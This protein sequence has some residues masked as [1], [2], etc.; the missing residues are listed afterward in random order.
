MGISFI[1][2]GLAAGAAL[3]A[4]P[5]ILHLLMRQTPKVVVFPALR[6]IRERSKQARKNMKI[7]NWLLL[8]ARMLLFV[9]MAL[10]L[11][12]PTYT[13]N[14]TMGDRE[15]PTALAL[16]F[17]TSLSMQ[18]TERNKDRLAEA[19]E[20]ALDLLSKTN[21][22][23]QVFVINSADPGVPV[24]LSP[25]A[26]KKQ[27]EALTLRPVNRK[28]NA[29]MGQAYSA[30]L[31][32]DRPRK[33]VYVLTDLARSAWDTGRPADGLDKLEKS[34][35]AVPTFVLRLSP[36]EPTNVG[37]VDAE[38]GTVAGITTTGESLTVKGV[39][40]STGPAA[41]RVVEFFL[42]GPTKRDQKRVDVPANGEAEVTFRTPKLD[43][44]LHQGRLHIAG[45][46]PM[47]FDDDRYVTFDVRPAFKV[48]VVYDLQD[49][50]AYIASALDP[51]DL[52]EGEPR[53]FKVDRVVSTRLTDSILGNLREYACVFVNNVRKLDEN[54]WRA[55]GTYVQNGGGLV[56][57]TGNRVDLA[58]YADATAARLLPATI[59]APKPA[60]GGQTSFGKI[61]Y[62]HPIFAR[63]PADLAALDSDLSSV[64]VGRYSVAAPAG[65]ARTLM[66]FQDG[67][68]ALI[69]RDVAGPKTG[70]VLLFTLPLSARP[71]PDDPAAWSDWPLPPHWSFF[72][73]LTQM[74]PYLAGTT[75]ERWNYQ[76]GEFISLPI[77]PA[78]R[79]TR[80]LVQGPGDTPPN[81]LTPP[82]GKASLLIEPPQ[83]IGQGSITATGADG[84][85]TP[86][87]FSI[88][89]D[90]LES[91]V[92][93]L[94]PKEL[95]QLLG[96]KKYALA[97]NADELKRVT[98]EVRVGREMF[99]WIMA[100]I[101]ALITAENF[102]ANRFHRDRG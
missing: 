75:S 101:L 18:Y 23:S 45:T 84:K 24:P 86:F 92:T 11:A 71:R 100:L 25:A 94:E 55:L 3:A 17:D 64:L 62:S 73:V 12:R 33:E 68:P 60:A 54:A 66:S 22:D 42:D 87:G 7:K 74:V 63:D 32:S 89:P 99:P 41:N 15:V 98:A 102:L 13:T 28:L 97:E 83:A 14:A 78:R 29:A 95:D 52:P 8:L 10:A 81:T 4:I 53:P 76:S 6:L 85:P 65:N 21:A 58:G 93:L 34:K 69:E 30:V 48:L 50:L 43:A 56:V 67:S 36:K 59:G 39:L 70:H 61:D 9:L 79:F 5:V 26:A 49:D 1:T 16:V 88:N 38:V 40:R 72:Y 37:L 91:A 44:G 80:F 27:V 57:A 2:A 51:A 77:D 31:E 20:R 47:P 82:A 46:D 35:A 96:E 90:P 19:K